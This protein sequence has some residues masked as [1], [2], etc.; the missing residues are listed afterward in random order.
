MSREVVPVI[1]S[2]GSGSRLWPLSREL[3]PKQFFP[4]AGGLTLLQGTVRRLA[5]VEPVSAPIVVC[6][7]AHRFMVLEQLRAIGVTPAAVLL[8][9][10]PRN[11]APAIAAAALEALA[12]ARPGCGVVNDGGNGNTDGGSTNGGD[13][14]GGD[15]GGGDT[16]GGIGGGNGGDRDAGP[17]AAGAAG[18][19]PL[20][21]VLPVDHVIRDEARFARSVREAVVE[22]GSGRLVTFGVP[23]AHP[24]TGYGYIRAGA[25]TGSG[26][27]ARAVERFIEK[28]DPD[29]AA[30]FLEDGRHYWNSGMFVFAARAFLREL[31][32]HSPDI[33]DA[34]VAAHRAAVQ[35]LDFL[36]LGAEPFAASP[37]V[38]V[39]H[40]VME[41]TAA[42]VMVPLDAG[43]S[44]IGSWTGMAGLGEPDGA[45][46]VVEGDVLLEDTR[47]TYVRG[48]E[49][50]VAAVGVTDLVIAD[51]ADAVLVAA[52][53]AAQNLRSVVATLRATG[54]EEQRTHRLV[55]RP[56]GRY[57]VLHGGD[58][59]KVKRIVVNPGHRLSLQSH[60]RRAEHWIVV[61]GAARVTRGDETFRVVENESTYIPPGTRHRLENPGESPLELVEV[62]TGR[63]LGEDDIV[64][65][66]DV[67]GRAGT[68]EPRRGG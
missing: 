8:E 7:E 18:A 44:D 63:Y 67:Y 25:P 13:T 32:L 15:T 57:E 61:R 68:G 21:L 27:R 17:G 53:G 40:A 50:L 23:P 35:D 39:D 45:G 29:A 47:N 49:R 60:R 34:V 3:H 46:N 16:D 64:R 56:W 59:F 2:G 9:P 14:D 51:T 54:R 11:T 43:W 48:A 22:A 52:K 33:H 24:E 58:G 4:L 28:P 62:Q 5:A 36:R 31:R 65:H 66:D 12:R 1:L 41:R 38:S 6:H 19:E 37:G 26:T 30:A 10:A 20:L 42:A 55:H